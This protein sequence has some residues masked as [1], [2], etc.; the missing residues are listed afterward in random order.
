LFFYIAK[1]YQLQKSASGGQPQTKE[2]LKFLEFILAVFGTAN[3][4]VSCTEK[5]ADTDRRA[6]IGRSNMLTLD[7]LACCITAMPQ[8]MRKVNKF[9]LAYVILFKYFMFLQ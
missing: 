8:L 2:Y 6:A 9:L 4:L 5:M 3:F 7:Y 1:R